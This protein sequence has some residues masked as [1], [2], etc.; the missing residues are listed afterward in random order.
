[1]NYMNMGSNMGNMS[2]M[3]QPMVLINTKQYSLPGAKIYNLQTRF[4][5]WGDFWLFFY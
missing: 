4:L 1:M 2:S 3:E 5:L